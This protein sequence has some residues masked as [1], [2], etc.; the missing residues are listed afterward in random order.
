MRMASIQIH[1]MTA[2]LSVG[3]MMMSAICNQEHTSTNAGVDEVIFAK[4]PTPQDTWGHTQR[5]G[6]SSGIL[7]PAHPCHLPGHLTVCLI[8]VPDLLGVVISFLLKKSIKEP[9]WR[10]DSLISITSLS[11]SGQCGPNMHGWKSPCSSQN[12]HKGNGFMKG[13]NLLKILLLAHL[14]YLPV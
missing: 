6:N 9:D 1:Q 5:V 14:H 3:C 8:S 10:S 13:N 4:G 2:W 12:T 7:P 11:V